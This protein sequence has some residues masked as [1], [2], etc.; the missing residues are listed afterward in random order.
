[1]KRLLAIFESNLASL[2]CVLFAIANRIIFTS[3]YSTIGRDTKVQITYAENLLAGKGMGVVKYFTTDLNTPVFDTYW[4]FPP[5]LSILLIPFLKIFNHNE[6]MAI[7]S[8]DIL[9]AILFVIAVRILGK[10]SGLPDS[11]INIVVLIAGCSQYPFFMSSSSTDVISLDLVLFALAA[12]ISI[13]NQ[14]KKLNLVAITC[15]SLLFFLPALFR[16]MYLPISILLPSLIFL[17]GY[18]VKNKQLK[19]TGIKLIVGTIVFVVLLLTITSTYSRS[20]VHVYNTG[21]GVF[22]DQVVR[23]YPFLPASIINLDFASQ[24]VEK[25][26]GIEY[27]K[28][29]FL[30]EILNAILFFLLCFLFFRFILRYKKDSFSNR[31]ILITSGSII[32]LVIILMLAYLSSTYKAQDWGE[33][34]WTYSYDIRYF[35]FIYI[36]I[37]LLLSTSIYFYPGVLKNIFAKFFLSMIILGFI[38]EVAHGIYYNVKIV[39]SHE[40]LSIIRERDKDYRSFHGIL[41]DLKNQNPGKEIFVCAPDQ[42]YLHTASQMGYKVIFDYT[43]LNKSDLKPA[44][45]SILVVPVHK[46]DAWIMKDY[47]EKKHPGIIAVIAGTTFYKEELD[48]Q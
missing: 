34:K 48:T 19:V 17:S 20:A 7:L 29:I 45:K 35:A 6:Y 27:S 4:F 12:M 36:L 33:Y 13:V 31:S 44:S 21:R 40:S 1:M 15:Y 38:I 5:G 3:L 46:Q 26:S 37:P 11:L 18:L 23:W 16:Y 2:F 41:Q 42:F 24:F 25:I 28:V 30:L 14:K 10:K 47:V 32:S 22:F 9:A 39:T 43:N 8:F